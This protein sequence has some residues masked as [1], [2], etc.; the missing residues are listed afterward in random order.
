TL[1]F[2]K[3]ELVGLDDKKYDAPYKAI[4]DLKEIASAFAIGRD[5]HVGD[6]II[7]IKGR[8]GF[9]AAE[10]LVILKAH[11]LLEKHT[12][13]KWQSYWKEQLSNWYGMFVHEGQFLD[14]V[15]RNIEK[16]LE[17]TQTTVSGKVF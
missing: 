3:G 13:T 5:V 2:E 8:V 16:F 6:T 15:M 9:E 17:D 4:Q 1:T 11:H 10:A 7:G 14:P 12:L